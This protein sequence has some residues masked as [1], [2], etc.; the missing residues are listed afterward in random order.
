MQEQN[1]SDPTGVAHVGGQDKSG[2]ARARQRKANAA[3]QMRLAGATW[4]E[5]ARTLGFPTARQALVAVEKALER[6]LHTGDRDQMR[7][8]AGARLERLLLSVWPKAIDSSNPEH[9]LAVT[10]AR[11]IVDRH[12]K[13]FGLDAPTEIVVHNPTMNELERWVSRV[14][15]LRMPTVEEYDILEGDI[16]DE[17][18]RA[19]ST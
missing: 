8:L 19:I 10:K 16:V 7:K 4:E 17:E 3:V 14:A 15:E 2:I 13:L 18:P 9:L 5:I 12:S 6:Q 1:S 11:E